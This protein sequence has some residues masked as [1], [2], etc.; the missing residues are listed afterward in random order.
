MVSCDRE[1]EKDSQFE[2]NEFVFVALIMVINFGRLRIVISH[3][4]ASLPP[5]V[6]NDYCKIMM[7]VM[8]MRTRMGTKR[9]SSSIVKMLKC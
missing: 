5:V 1:V 3:V 4:N 2:M 9:M 7:I 8:M 6:M